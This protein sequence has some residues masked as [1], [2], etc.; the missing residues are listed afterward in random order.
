[1]GTERGTRG[2]LAAK[3]MT[4]EEHVRGRRPPPS[5]TATPGSL[6]PLLSQLSLFFLLLKAR[7]GL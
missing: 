1:M 5:T 3:G 7:Q 4:L 2:S 6:F